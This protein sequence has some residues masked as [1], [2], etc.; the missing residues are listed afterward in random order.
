M[1]ITGVIA[2]YNPF[3]PGHAWHLAQARKD[4]AADYVIAVMSTCFT[5]RGDAALLP[6]S[7]RVRMALQHG[8]DAV[9]ALPCCWAVRDGEHFA[10]GGVSILDR[11]GC[12][13]ISFGTEC[14]NLAM[15]SEA[16]RL[17][18]SP[19][20]AFTAAIRLRLNDGVPYPA[21]AASA[22]E[23][24]LP[25]SGQ[26]SSS[27]NSTL[28]LCY[29][30]AI[31][32]TGSNMEVYPVRRDSAYH[33][34]ALGNSFP[35]ATALRGAVLRGDWEK[36]SQA[37]S[38]D[39]FSIV[40][41]AARN[42]LIHRPDA[43]DAALL[44][45]LRTMS[46]EAYRNL[47]DLSEGIE[48]RLAAAACNTCTRESLILAA[49]TRRYPYARLSR[50]ATHALLGM[51]QQALSEQ[52]LP[53]AAWL[54]GLRREARGLFSL[55]KERSSLPIIG[56]AADYTSDEPWFTLEKRAYDIWALGVGLPSGL[57]M[58]QGVVIV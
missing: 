25:G 14:D 18:E 13:A 55:L 3:H 41:D 44:F 58:T 17:L 50:L 24:A 27:P 8:A 1:R 30:R 53:P 28:A 54:L 19:D 15:L 16:A 12:D 39:C 22:L 49:K 42:H 6:P 23:A 33:A 34:T 56:K 31:L 52:P 4:S 2:E 51:T 46:P 43:L 47:P 37:M 36:V 57:A 5:Q 40:Q 10:L 21:A 38:P 48:D 7:A 32:R 20:D 26:L 35:S 45:R 9:F 29:L 11:L